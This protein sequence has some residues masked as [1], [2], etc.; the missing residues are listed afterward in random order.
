M[1]RSIG[2]RLDRLAALYQARGCSTCTS[3]DT[4]TVEIGTRDQL[5]VHRPRPSTCPNC[6]RRPPNTTAVVQIIMPDADDAGI[7]A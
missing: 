3:W 7:G 6:G 2:R 5:P 4:T 1:S